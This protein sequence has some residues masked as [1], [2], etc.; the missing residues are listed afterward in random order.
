MGRRLAPQTDRLLTPDRTDRC[1][2]ELLPAAAVRA[3]PDPRG[4]DLTGAVG[5]RNAIQSKFRDDII[6]YRRTVLALH[7][8]GYAGYICVE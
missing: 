5:L 6:D 3:G 1:Q 2:R 4:H 8:A 7:E